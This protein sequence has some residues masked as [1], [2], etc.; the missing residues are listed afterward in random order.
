MAPSWAKWKFLF[1]EM[2]GGDAL[3]NCWVESSQVESASMTLVDRRG[4]TC[5]QGHCKVDCIQAVE[6]A[7]ILVVV[8]VEPGTFRIVLC[9]SVAMGAHRVRDCSQILCSC[10]YFGCWRWGQEPQ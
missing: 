7:W 2:P 3:V 9:R 1:V 4:G 10:K 8:V 6:V 5:M